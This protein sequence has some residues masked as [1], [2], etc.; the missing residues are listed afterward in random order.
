V[1]KLSQQWF[2]IF[3]AGDYGPKGRFS[4][5]DL[6]SIVRNYQPSF[7]E[8]PLCV[9]HPKD[10]LPAYGWV[11]ALRR[12]GDTLLCKSKQVDPQFEEMVEQGR[13]KKRSAGFYVTPKG[14]M[15]R[16]VAF[17]GAQPPDVKGLQD[18]KFEDSD[19]K[20][21][22]I[23]FEEEMVDANEKSFL[24]QLKAFFA[25]AS[26]A[27]PAEAAPV[28]TFSED[29]VK[30]LIGD[31]V[32]PFTDKIATLENTL[33]TQQT[34]FA[35]AERKRNEER[36]G[37]SAVAA[38]DK[39]K[40]DGK[41][42]PA[43]DKMQVPQLFSELAKNTTVTIE[44]SEGD[45]KENRSLLDTAVSIFGALPKIVPAGEVAQGSKREGTAVAFSENPGSTAVADPN[46]VALYEAAKKV[47]AEKKIDFAE[48]LVEVSR[49]HPELC[50]PGGMT[51]GQV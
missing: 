24:D 27:K 37:A 1:G 48:A 5:S 16:H 32:K 11:E 21:T 8:A 13:F 50:K 33:N 3:R 25:G 19:R 9:G 17:L 45:K 41:W 51:A 15:L 6:D 22:E 34:N 30:K 4:A 38:I 42:I 7:H 26:L 31:A 44:F 12:E 39:L 14:H 23:A 10:N 40:A 29:D 43:F 18:V 2:E 20:V 36:L 35:E 47:A 49:E 46:S 28:K